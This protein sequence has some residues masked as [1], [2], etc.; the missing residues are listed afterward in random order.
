[1]NTYKTTYFGDIEA[2]D[3]QELIEIETSVRDEGKDT[4]ISIIIQYSGSC[5]ERMSEIIDLLDNY[6]VLHKAAKRYIRENYENNDDMIDFLFRYAG[7]LGK[8]EYLGSGSKTF[9]LDID[10]MIEKL[11]PPTLGFHER[12]NGKMAAQLSYYGP[13]NVDLSLIITIDNEL[14]IYGVEYYGEY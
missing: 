8:L 10:R 7:Q 4:D 9:T 12:R 5:K 2:E 14:K 13:E 1:M 3:D 6:F 11:E